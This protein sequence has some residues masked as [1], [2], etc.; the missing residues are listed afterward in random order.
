MLDPTSIKSSSI[1][2]S[3]KCLPSFN[4]A[5]MFKGDKLSLKEVYQITNDKI[6]DNNIDYVIDLRTDEEYNLNAVLLLN[7]KNEEAIYMLMIL[8]MNQS[9]FSEV[10]TLL[11]RF[12]LVCSSKCTKKDEIKKKLKDISITDSN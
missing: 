5:G 7:P 3:L 1:L 10:K 12:E 4:I 11:E 6:L 8:K 9:N 2:S